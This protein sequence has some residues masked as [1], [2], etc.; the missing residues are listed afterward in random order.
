M[1]R[2]DR[3]PQS[4]A[5]AGAGHSTLC[6]HRLPV[7]GGESRHESFLCGYRPMRPLAIRS[8]SVFVKFPLITADELMRDRRVGAEMTCPSTRIAIGR[9]MWLSVARSIFAAPPGLNAT[10][11]P[12]VVGVSP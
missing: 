6:R 12:N 7:I 11:T 4:P 5:G 10:A 2:L 3:G 9:P 1:N 8:A